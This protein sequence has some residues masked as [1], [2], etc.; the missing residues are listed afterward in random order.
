MACNIYLLSFVPRTKEIWHDQGRGTL[1]KSGHVS[2]I[3][4]SSVLPA[5][6]RPKTSERTNRSGAPSTPLRR[7]CS[8]SVATAIRSWDE[9]TSRSVEL[10]ELCNKLVMKPFVLLKTNWSSYCF[11]NSGLLQP[12]HIWFS[13]V[14]G[15]TAISSVFHL[16]NSANSALRSAVTLQVTVRQSDFD[17][18]EELPRITRIRRHAF[19]WHRLSWMI[20]FRGVIDA[21]CVVTLYI[22]VRVTIFLRVIFCS[23]EPL[24]ALDTFL[25]TSRP[26]QLCIWFTTVSAIHGL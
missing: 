12:K 16:Q 21:I 6:T 14:Y 8:E 5:S 7:P 9:V 15:F 3:C 18:F 17:L 19:P 4:M 24:S 11:K 23:K 1:D 10:H 22:S 2:I 20:F 25:S 26:T 13:G